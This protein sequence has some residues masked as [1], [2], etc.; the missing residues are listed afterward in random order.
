MR[1]IKRMTMPRTFALLCI[2]SPLLAYSQCGTVAQI[3][4]AD[5]DDVSPPVHG[6]YI[7]LEITA[8]TPPFELFFGSYAISSFN[9]G[10][11]TEVEVL[12]GYGGGG[13]DDQFTLVDG[14]GCS[15]DLTAQQWPIYVSGGYPIEVPYGDQ[16]C[17][18]DPC[19][20]VPWDLLPNDGGITY[21]PFTGLADVRL[22][23]LPSRWEF[24]EASVY[25][26]SGPVSMSGTVL[27]LP[28]DDLA[29]G[30]P[31][32]PRVLPDLPS[33][34]YSLTT[35]NNGQSVW[36][37]DNGDEM[38]DCN[39]GTPMSTTF[40]VPPAP[41]TLGDD[42]VNVNAQIALQ[43]AMPSGGTVM[44]DELRS[45]GYLPTSEPYTALGYIY[46]DPGLSGA[47]VDPA[48]FNTTG[49]DA[50]VDWVVVELRSASAPYP[51]L[52]SRPALVQ[53]DGDVVDLDGDQYVNFP[54]LT[55]GNYR[56]AVRHRNHLGIMRS[57]SVLLGL[58]PRVVNLRT[59]SHYGSGATTTINGVKC[60]W[61][62]NVN[63]NDRITY[64]GAS[65][66][67]DPILQEIGG[68]NPNNTALG[69]SGSDVNLD[70]MIKYT[71]SDNDRD[72][73]LM[74]IGGVVPTSTRLEQL[75]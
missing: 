54:S 69:Y 19:V 65:N 35:T 23:E 4:P 58:I 46:T 50:I 47:A 13:L 5:C 73:I 22:G 18:Y 37:D 74:N 44:D 14:N 28:P 40:T 33:G 67:R 6:V 62:G 52:A 27:S 1:P 36:V 17:P 51:V 56:V 16:Y 11:Y 41:F 66:D 2:L 12:A 21:D 42:G 8:G 25:S 15:T 39:Y 3:T 55:T 9:L 43:G 34:I 53:R 31:C 49:N 68:S 7:E 26:L 70:G 71:G 57:S 20:N 30:C 29:A 32:A 60:M 10:L 72:P 61:S 38:E 64:V 48:L 24:L 59:G 45:L 75:P 63:F